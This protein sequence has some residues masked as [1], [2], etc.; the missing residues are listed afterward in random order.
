MPIQLHLLGGFD[1]RSGSGAVL[2]FPTSKVRALF[3]YLATN[4][5]LGHR[6]DKLADF[7]W[8]DV[9]AGEGRTNLRKAL[10][11]LRQSPRGTRETALQPTE[12]SS[13]SGPAPWRWMS[14]CSAARGRGH[15]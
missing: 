2:T 11:R 10:S 13:P 14:G 4:P 3:A 8:G 7:L 9:T 15:P 6:R 1:C 12:T 5:E